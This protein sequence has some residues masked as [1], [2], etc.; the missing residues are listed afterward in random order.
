[1]NFSALAYKVMTDLNIGY[2]GLDFSDFF[3]LGIRHDTQTLCPPA[4][5][6]NRQIFALNVNAVKNQLTDQI[7]N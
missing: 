5:E 3:I 2:P 7:V 4:G 1:M 6:T